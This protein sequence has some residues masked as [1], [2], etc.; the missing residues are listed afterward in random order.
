MLVLIPAAGKGSR[1]GSTLPKILTLVNGE[2]I[3]NYILNSI[4]S[5]ATEI[6]I[7]VSPV[8]FQDFGQEIKNLDTRIRLLTQEVP[9]GMGDAIFRNYNYWK[10][11]EKIILVWGDQILVQKKTLNRVMRI[12]SDGADLVIP[13][14]EVENPYVQYKFDK[15]DTL[16]IFQQR[17]GE[18]VD[19]IGYSD[20]GVFGLKTKDLKLAWDEYS[21]IQKVGNITGEINFLPFLE[22]MAESKFIVKYFKTDFAWET[23]GINTYSDV[24]KAELILNKIGD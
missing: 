19:S 1:L 16:K 3:I 17:E 14:S 9:L 5:L 4:D 13:L 6:Q 7:I 10:H 21:D 2:P 22:F 24:Y 20:V 8:V 18:I 23:L 11:F 15:N 12:L